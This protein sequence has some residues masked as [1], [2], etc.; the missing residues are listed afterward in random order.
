M[1]TESAADTIAGRLQGPVRVDTSYGQ[2]T[3]DVRRRV[4]VAVITTG[5]ELVPAGAAP[6][7]G[8]VFDANRVALTTAVVEAGAELVLAGSSDDDIAEFLRLLRR[9]TDVADLVITSGGISQGA[10]EVVRESLEPLG[11]TIGHVDMQ[12]G[13]PQA[14]AV[15]DGVPI[16]CFPGNPVSTQV[17]FV[18]F[19]RPILRRAAGLPELPSTARRLAGPLASVAGKRRFLRGRVRGDGATVFASIHLC[20]PPH[21]PT[22]VDLRVSGSSRVFGDMRSVDTFGGEYRL[23][24]VFLSLINLQGIGAA[25]HV[26]R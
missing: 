25:C 17:S 14:T 8:Q 16:I 3:V 11:A 13:G 20:Q 18:V 21:G 6:G 1:T 4:R 5:A 22:D 12:P 26:P 2:D 10:Y 7:P 23:G 15:V 9:A 19:L 24:G